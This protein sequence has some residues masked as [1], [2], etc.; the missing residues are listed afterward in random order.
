MLIYDAPE[1]S[2]VDTLAD[3]FRLERAAY[4]MPAQAGRMA[5]GPAP[6]LLQTMLTG[7]EYD[8]ERVRTANRPAPRLLWDPPN[9]AFPA[10][11]IVERQRW[12]EYLFE[13]KNRHIEAFWTRLSAVYQGSIPLP[14]AMPGVEPDSA[15]LAWDTEKHHLDVTILADGLAEWF[16]MN[17][18]TGELRDGTFPEDAAAFRELLRVVAA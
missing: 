1:T 9:G 6:R 14:L 10:A 4:V 3:A 13:H 11:T 17:R 2:S 16:F 18:E 5:Y 12:G 15:Q 7:G 8:L